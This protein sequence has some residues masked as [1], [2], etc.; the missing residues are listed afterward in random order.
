[1]SLHNRRQNIKAE[2]IDTERLL[3]M[4]RSHPLMADSLQ[5][6]IEMLNDEL[7]KIPDIIH[8]PVMQF[9]FSGNAVYGSDGIKSTFVS[10]I[11]QPVQG[12]VQTQLAINK[13]GKVGKRGRTKKKVK[14]DLYLTGLPK[15]SFGIEL[16][17]IDY[18]EHDLYDLV[19]TSEAMKDVINLIKNTALEEDL[20]SE[21]IEKTPKRNLS[22]LKKFLQEVVNENSILKMD[23]GEVHVELSN[24][25]V[26][27]AY[28]RISTVIENEDEIIIEGVLRGMLLDSNK[29]EILDTEGKPISGYINNELDEET[30]IEYDRLYLNQNCKIHLRV[31]YINYASKQEKIEYELLE[32]ERV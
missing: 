1:M 9:L 13:Y 7:S 10:K 16:T 19:D 31:Y 5:E 2:I 32:I 24:E 27:K 22:N 4:V 30:L 23:S 8:E 26:N 25:Q 28:R 3:E 21:I 18:D 29:F 15:G 12:L 14:N 17:R 11:T 20:F 6:K